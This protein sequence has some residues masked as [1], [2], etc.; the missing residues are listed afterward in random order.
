MNEAIYIILMGST[1]EDLEPNVFDEY[2][3]SKRCISKG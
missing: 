1:V 3:L 2:Y